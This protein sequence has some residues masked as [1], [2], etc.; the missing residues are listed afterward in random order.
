LAYPGGLTSQQIINLALQATRRGP[1]FAPQ[2]AQ[3]YILI[4]RD[5]C[6]NQ[7]LAINKTWISLTLDPAAPGPAGLSGF[8][9]GMGPNVLPTNYLRAADNGV[10]YSFNG[11]PYRMTETELEELFYLG[12]MPASPANPD[13]WAT[14]FHNIP[15]PVP[16]GGIQAATMYVYPP[17]QFPYQVNLQY[18][19]LQDDPV[20]P[21]NTPQIPWFPDHQYLIKELQAQLMDDEEMHMQA[22]KILNRYLQNEPDTERMAITMKLDPRQ[23][24]PRGSSGRLPPQKGMDL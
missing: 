4:L 13:M 22:Q 12:L 10:N 1:N 7:D 18:Y 23:F 2:A 15:I 16:F 6:F 21:A 3:K 24:R 19:R 8:A 17:T 11:S 9:L 14:D 20:N 5:L